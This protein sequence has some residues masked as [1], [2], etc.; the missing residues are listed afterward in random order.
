M[1]TAE[2]RNDF[3]SATR[4]RLPSLACCSPFGNS[5]EWAS[6]PCH[7]DELSTHAAFQWHQRRAAPS[8]ASRLH[9]RPEQAVHHLF[10]RLGAQTSAST[11]TYFV[12]PI[13][14]RFTHHR[15]SWTHQP[16]Q[17]STR[18]AQTPF[19]L[20]SHHFCSVQLCVVQSGQGR[21]QQSGIPCRWYHVS[22]ATNRSEPNRERQARR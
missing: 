20:V 1:G 6:V 16:S 18:S 17:C 2:S 19:R 3:A 14:T 15:H 4:D 8:S 5:I 9:D 12:Q 11:Y 21:P 7:A 13:R 22:I 10:R